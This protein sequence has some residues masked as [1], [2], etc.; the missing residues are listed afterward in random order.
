MY[1]LSKF[2]NSSLIHRLQK[3]F[4]SDDENV[5]P[6]ARTTVKGKNGDG[7]SGDGL[8]SSNLMSA[9]D[10][11]KRFRKAERKGGVI[12]IYQSDFILLM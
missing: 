6:T 4:A 8:D 3:G 7:F 11:S 5:P 12:Y 1:L 2:K 10:A 9:E